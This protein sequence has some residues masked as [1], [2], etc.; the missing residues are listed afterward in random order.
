MKQYPIAC[1]PPC[2][3]GFTLLEVLA[4]VAMS[5]M[6]LSSLYIV[7]SGAIRLR[8]DDSKAFQEGPKRSQVAALLKHDL[9][10]CVAPGGVLAGAMIGSKVED[11]DRREDTLEIYTTTG[12]LDDDAPWAE[13]QKV[14]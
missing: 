10:N 12:R 7:M 2:N 4:A 11:I 1:R 3:K 8:E 5:A 13:I 9:M 6:L 14:Q